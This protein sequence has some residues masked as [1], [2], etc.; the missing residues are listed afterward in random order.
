MGK[1]RWQ[2][3]TVIAAQLRDGRIYHAQLLE[4]PFVALF[5]GSDGPDGA[6]ADVTDVVRHPVL[7]VLAVH[8][9][10][11]RQWDVI[12]QAP[13]VTRPPVEQFRQT[14]GF[15]EELSVVNVASGETRP[16]TYSET[17]GL[18]AQAIWEPEHVEDLLVAHGH[19]EVDPWTAS[20]RLIDPND[21]QDPNER[22]ET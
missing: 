22:S 19:G 5:D 4:F 15:P 3:G 16:A 14:R 6:N 10:L 2:P 21:Q 20:L 11:L 13:P 7:Q 18:S 8:R 1:A 17:R 9:D 12:G